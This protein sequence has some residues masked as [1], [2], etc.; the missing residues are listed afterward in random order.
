LRR[1][2]GERISGEVINE[3]LAGARTEAEIAGPVGCWRS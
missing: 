1:A 2:G 3:L